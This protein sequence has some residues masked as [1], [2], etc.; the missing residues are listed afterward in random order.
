MNGYVNLQC[1]TTEYYL[2]IKTNLE[3]Y[4]NTSEKS[5]QLAMGRCILYYQEVK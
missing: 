1:G 2:T 3:N 5:L 4:I